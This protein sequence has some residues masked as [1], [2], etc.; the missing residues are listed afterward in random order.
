MRA[1]I[2]QHNS[3]TKNCFV[4]LHNDDW[5]KKQRIAGKIAGQAISLLETLVKN[6]TTKSMIELDKIAEEFIR[7]NGCTPTFLNY[8]GFPNSVC[9]SINKQLVHGICTDYILQDG[10]L[11]SFDLGATYEGAIGDTATTV[12]FGEAHNE[13][14][15]RLVKATQ[16]ALAAAIKS[17]KIGARLEVIGETIANI[18]KQYGYAIVDRYGGH[19]LDYNRPHADPFISNT[20]SANNGIRI[21]SNMTLAIEPLF[22]IGKSNA[23][24]VSKD[25]WTVACDNICAHEE[26]TIYIS[27]NN[28]EIITD[29]KDI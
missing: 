20:G 10:D 1:N 14:H 21:Q 12:I 13:E 9:V 19:S 29:R 25:G 11:V 6:K 15:I 3:F 7:N 22:V 17:V 4:K 26:H 27:E 5:L 8:M 16:E 28:I 23:T 24:H 2:L 18:G